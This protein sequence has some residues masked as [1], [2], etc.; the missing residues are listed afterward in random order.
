M[1]QEAN[2]YKV[3]L[4][5]MLAKKLSCQNWLILFPHSISEFIKNFTICINTVNPKTQCPHADLHEYAWNQVYIIYHRVYLSTVCH[6]GYNYITPTSF[7]IPP[8]K[9][10]ETIWCMLSTYYLPAC[11]FCLEEIFDGLVT[12]GGCRLNGGNSRWVL[13]CGYRPWGSTTECDLYLFKKGSWEK[14]LSNNLQS[15]T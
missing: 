12:E 11:S 14:Q 8:C 2:M 3:S 15:S 9:L 13:C 7:K 1:D 6:D 5:L 4:I 10:T